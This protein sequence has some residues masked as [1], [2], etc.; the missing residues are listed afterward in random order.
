MFWGGN[1][2]KVLIID[3]DKLVCSSLKTI[4]ESDKNIQVNGIGYNG[5]DAIKLYEELKPDILLMDIRMD[6]MTGLEAGEI[7]LKKYPAS[8]IIY[9]TTFNDDSYIIMALKIGAKGYLLKQNFECI[10]PSIK[11]VESGQSV[12]GEEIISKIPGMINKNITQNFSQFGLNEK[13]IKIIELV[14]DGLSN[15]E[16]A[17]KLY[18]AEGTIRNYLSIILEKLGLRDRTKLAIFYYKNLPSLYYL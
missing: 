13:E 8:K 4:I 17:S 1:F 7:I 16:I 10:I 5:Y 12:F 6:N 14:A 3:D 2:M 18:L 11:A 15:K 9:L